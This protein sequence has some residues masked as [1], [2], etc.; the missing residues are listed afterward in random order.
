LIDFK[1]EVAVITGAASGIGRGIAEK[2]AKE[3][4]SLPMFPEL[5]EE[6]IQYTIHEIKQF[7]TQQL[8]KDKQCPEKV[9]LLST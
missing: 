3:L 1:D 5:S 2:C 4:V 9:K 8:A 6:Q 7:I